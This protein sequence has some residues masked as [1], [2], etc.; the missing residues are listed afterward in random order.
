MKWYYSLFFLFCL[1]SAFT[2]IEQPVQYPQ[3]EKNYY[4]TEPVALS[5]HWAF[6]SSHVN[7][8]ITI[9]YGYFNYHKCGGDIADRNIPFLSF[10]AQFPV[11]INKRYERDEIL[12][13]NQFLPIVTYLDGKEVD[14]KGYQFSALGMFDALGW[15]WIT[16]GTTYGFSFGQRKMVSFVKDKKYKVKNPFFGLVGGLDL[17]FNV[18]KSA[19]LS[20][21]GYAN[22]MVDLTKTRWINKK[23][24]PFTIPKNTKFTG[25]EVGVAIGFI[26]FDED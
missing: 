16:L 26:L 2:Q 21:G 10:E 1:Q 19:G 5:D 14:L 8:P 12:R 9:G 6:N 13:Y 15:K 24:Y 25:W 20:F 22:Y 11:V 18:G 17:R 7:S 4:Y 23:D 3:P